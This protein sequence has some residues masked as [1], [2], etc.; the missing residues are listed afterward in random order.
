[1]NKDSLINSVIEEL[2]GE[3]CSLIRF[4]YGDELILNFGMLC[5]FDHPKL[6]HLLK[7]KWRLCMSA[8]P[9]KLTQDGVCIVDGSQKDIE[10]VER[11][12]RQIERKVVRDIC[13]NNNSYELHIELQGEYEFIVNPEL[14]DDSGLSYWEL[15]QT[16]GNALIVGPGDSW[17]YGR[18]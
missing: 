14:E 9:W 17:S 11:V 10:L 4:S 6:Q 7:G 5:P 12:L 1:M 15:F 2:I 16:G 3:E 8:S 18:E 13:F